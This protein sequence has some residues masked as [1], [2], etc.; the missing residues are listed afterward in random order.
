MSGPLL[1]CANKVVL[2]TQQCSINHPLPRAVLIEL[3]DQDKIVWPI[4]SKLL[5][6][7]AERVFPFNLKENE[8]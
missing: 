5:N 6:N 8:H 2:G 7:F 3:N 1:V 4:E